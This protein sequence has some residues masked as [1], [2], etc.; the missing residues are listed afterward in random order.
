MLI[1]RFQAPR[2]PSMPTPISQQSPTPVL[3]SLN[4]TAYLFPMDEP[5]DEPIPI[6][7]TLIEVTGCRY[8]VN[9]NPP[10]LFCDEEKARYSSY[11]SHHHA[12]CFRPPPDVRPFV[13]SQS[14]S[15]IVARPKPAKPVTVR[16]LKPP[17]PE[18]LQRPAGQWFS[19]GSLRQRVYAAILDNP[20]TIAQLCEATELPERAVR[21]TCIDLNMPATKKDRYQVY[22]DRKA[23]TVWITANIDVETLIA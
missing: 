16:T 1:K 2:S 19:D 17:K 11:C 14:R 15:N 5:E 22:R 13:E 3:S 7:I 18:K 20:C 23:G 12:V 9:D 4:G 21:E 6:G 10:F 8:P